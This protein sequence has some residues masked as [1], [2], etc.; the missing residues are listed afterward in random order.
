M[1]KNDSATLLWKARHIG[2]VSLS[3]EAP[4]ASRLSL[5]ILWLRRQTISRNSNESGIAVVVVRL[6]FRLSYLR[7]IRLKTSCQ[8]I[9]CKSSATT[10]LPKAS[11]Q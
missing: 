7:K 9:Q 4:S 1:Q 2:D 3:I 11:V 6:H 5:F 8:C 10:T